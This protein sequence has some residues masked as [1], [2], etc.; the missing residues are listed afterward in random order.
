MEHILF[1]SWSGLGR[2]AVVGVAA[3]AALVLMLRVSGTRSLAKLNAFDLVVTVALGSTLA[4]T[5]LSKTVALAEGVAAF[6]LL[7]ILQ[8][9]IAWGAVRSERFQRLTSAGPTL[10]DHQGFLPGQMRHARVSSE[11]LR[12]V[13]RDSGHARRRRP[14]TGHLQADRPMTQRA[15]QPRRQPNDV[16]R[17]TATTARSHRPAPRSDATRARSTVN[18]VGGS[19]FAPRQVGPSRPVRVVCACPSRARSRGTE[20]FKEQVIVTVTTTLEM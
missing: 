15:D 9:V 7:L 17:R 4:S 2:V 13:V 12:Q 16:P 19:C 3:Y 5:L 11:D 14:R 1:Q 18:S 20:G 10:L 8:S 6:A